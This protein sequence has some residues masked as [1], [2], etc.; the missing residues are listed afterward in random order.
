M[1]LSEAEARRRFTASRT[2]CLATASLNAEPHL[3]VVTFAVVGDVV[4]TAVDQKPKTT[5]RLRRLAL[6]EENP[7]VSM[8]ADCYDD[9]DWSRLWWCRADGRARVLVEPEECAEPLAWLS[10]K[11][12]Q[13][14]TEPPP[15][16]VIWVD[17]TR[18]QGWAYAG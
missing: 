15:G 11:Y 6:I 13:Y 1:R 14:A 12:P 4:V 16:P 5:R 3:V 2:A 10:S 7:Q 17:V 9:D 8:L 18:W